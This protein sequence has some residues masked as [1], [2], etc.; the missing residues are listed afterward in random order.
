MSNNVDITLWANGITDNLNQWHILVERIA[1]EATFHPVSRTERPILN[2]NEYT[3]QNILDSYGSPVREVTQA[4]KSSMINNGFTDIY[5]EIFKIGQDSLH[6]L[7]LFVKSVA[8]Y[9]ID[10]PQDPDFALIRIH[11]LRTQFSNWYHDNSLE[12]L[13]DLWQNFVDDNDDLHNLP[14]YAFN[15]IRLKVLALIFYEHSVYL[16]FPNNIPFDVG[17][18]VIAPFQNIFAMASNVVHFVAHPIAD[19]GHIIEKFG[20][21]TVES[22]VN[23]KK[24]IVTNEFTAWSNRHFG[25]NLSGKCIK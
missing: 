11:Q 20:E 16:V 3:Y 21:L 25:S 1:Y 5:H 8:Y 7:T 13:E 6:Q 12:E 4:L 19:S 2:I 17:Y 22:V 10:L 23:G 9:R 15:V 14:A 24:Q 18:G